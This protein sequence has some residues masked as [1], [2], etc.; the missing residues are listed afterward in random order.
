MKKDHLKKPLNAFMLY[1][2]HMRTSGEA[3]K[4]FGDGLGREMASKIGERWRSADLP[5]AEKRK[6]EDKVS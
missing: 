2:T 3:V 5:A 1:S 4:L 6:W